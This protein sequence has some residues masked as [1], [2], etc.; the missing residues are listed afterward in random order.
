MTS[1]LSDCMNLMPL[2]TVY[3]AFFGLEKLKTGQ[4]NAM[5]VPRFI[6]SRP[7]KSELQV[8]LLWSRLSVTLCSSKLLL[9]QRAVE[10]HWFVVFNE[11]F[12]APANHVAGSALLYFHAFLHFYVS[13]PNGKRFVG[14]KSR[15]VISL[16]SRFY[17]A[18]SVRVFC[19][20]VELL[21]V[22]LYFSHLLPICEALSFFVPCWL[23]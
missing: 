13:G 16:P 19:A 7:I 22:L 9:Y 8:L 6:M 23:V 18:Q 14:D 21:Y 4:Q 12:E 5:F 10:K 20:V 3:V 1:S 17:G 15:L 2:S 11:I